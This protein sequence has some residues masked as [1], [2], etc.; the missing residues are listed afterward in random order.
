MRRLYRSSYH[1]TPAFWIEHHEAC[2]YDHII[3]EYPM[4]LADKTHHIQSATHGDR[5]WQ[6]LL[7]HP[8]R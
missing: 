1:L 7:P 4:T 8:H 6:R 5:D 2:T 3:H